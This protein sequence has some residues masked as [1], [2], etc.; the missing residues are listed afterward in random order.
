MIGLKL[1]GEDKIH[2]CCASFCIDAS[3]IF[4]TPLQKGVRVYIDFDGIEAPLGEIIE[5]AFGFLEPFGI[6]SRKSLAILEDISQ[7]EIVLFFKPSNPDDRFHKELL[8]IPGSL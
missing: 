6:S 4:S 1:F 2:V 5:K 8:D 7:K 3:S